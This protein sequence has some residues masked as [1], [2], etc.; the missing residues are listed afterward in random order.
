MF[1]CMCSVFIAIT[2]A[3]ACCNSSGTGKAHSPGHFHSWDYCDISGGCDVTAA[4]GKP[5]RPAKDSVTSVGNTYSGPTKKSNASH[6]HSA[7]VITTTSTAPLKS[8]YADPAAIG[9]LGANKADNFESDDQI[10]NQVDALAKYYLAVKY[11]TGAD[12]ISKNEEEAARL[13]KLA[14]DLGSAP[15]E[16]SLG[17]YYANGQ[18]G[19]KQSDQ[20]AARLYK[21]AA[22]QGYALAEYRL[23]VLYATGQGS[24]IKDN[25]KAAQFFELAANH[26][27]VNAEAAELLSK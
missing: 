18:G 19:L 20:E 16:Y 3:C 25:R 13:Y 9:P 7:Q 24:L 22:D 23:G 11:A 8:T 14:V 6:I 26:G 10:R 17:M 27:Y 1:A 21:L 4:T 2:P 5:A 15:A 12:G